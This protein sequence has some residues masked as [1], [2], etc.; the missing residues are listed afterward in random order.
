M[1]GRTRVKSFEVECPMCGRTHMVRQR[2]HKYCNR[3]TRQERVSFAGARHRQTTAYL[4]QKAEERRRQRERQ[5]RTNVIE[6]RGPHY[7][8]ALAIPYAERLEP[9]CQGCSVWHSCRTGWVDPATCSIFVEKANPNLYW[10]HV[11]IGN[12]PAPAGE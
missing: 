5:G 4:L 10:A 7:P 9:P 1:S 3:H 2:N 12:I 8:S 6:R 11:V